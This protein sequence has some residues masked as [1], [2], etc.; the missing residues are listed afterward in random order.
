LQGACPRDASAGIADYAPPCAID[1]WLSAGLSVRAV[2]EFLGDKEAI[3]QQA[4]RT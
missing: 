4:Y 2:A 3:V 1:A